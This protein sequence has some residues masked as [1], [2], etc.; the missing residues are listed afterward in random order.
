MF[1]VGG[2]D[3]WALLLR[4][5]GMKGKVVVMDV[6]D[7]CGAEVPRW[8]ARHSVKTRQHHRLLIVYTNIDNVPVAYTKFNV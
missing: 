2:R 1:I 5:D 7:I 4:W 8:Q 3:G 6:T